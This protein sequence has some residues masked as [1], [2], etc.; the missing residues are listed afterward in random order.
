[1]NTYSKVM[2]RLENNSNGK[3]ENQ[4]RKL[5]PWL[6]LPVERILVSLS[7]LPLLK[8][9]SVCLSICIF[10][11]CLFNMINTPSLSHSA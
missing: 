6:Y 4:K 8:G 3:G 1:M 2:Y 7:H 5:L 10:P 11:V 9:L